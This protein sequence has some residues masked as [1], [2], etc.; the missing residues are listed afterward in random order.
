ME[1]TATAAGDAIAA[2]G[3]LAGGLILCWF[4]VIL[5]L[6]AGSIYVYYKI[7]EKTGNSGWL[8][9]L[10]FVP[11]ANLG[12]ILYLAFSD[13][14]VLRENRDLRA[15]LGYPPSSI[16]GP[17]TGAYMPPVTNY[18]PPP[19]APTAPGG[20]VFPPQPQAPP[21]Q[22]QPSAPQAPPAAAPPSAPA[23]TAPPAPVAPQWTEPVTPPAPPSGT[24][25]RQ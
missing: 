5:L 13:W 19:Q 16:P 11:I 18:G 10:M 1:S 6:I 4:L 14:P 23:H 22:Q 25:E 3:S 17:M 8:A 21:P 15:R 7:F 2:I 24:E 20:S 12:L 9:L